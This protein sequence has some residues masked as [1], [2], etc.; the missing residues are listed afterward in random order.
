[1]YMAK[2]LFFSSKTGNDQG[3]IIP[4]DVIDF[5]RFNRNPI[6][7]REHEWKEDP[8]GLWTDIQ[9]SAAGWSGIPVFHALTPESER[10][11]KLYDGDWIRGASI[12]GLAIWKTNAADQYVLDKNGFRQCLKF[13][14]YEISIVTLPSNPDAVTDEPVALSARVYDQGELNSIEQSITTLSS[15]FYNNMEK[16]NDPV[17]NT[18]QTAA[19]SPE[20]AA[21]AAAEPAARPVEG[22]GRI[23]LS[24]NDLPGFLGKI[25]GSVKAAL[26]IDT[27]AAISAPAHK[28]VPVSTK[29]DK[30][31]AE[32][33][34]APTGLS[35]VAEKAK[36][37]AESKLEAAEKA[38]KK[39]EQAKEK[40]EAENASEE[41]KAEHQKSMEA[42]KQAV[43]EAE[44]AQADY[45]N[46]KK[47]EDKGEKNT[48]TAAPNITINVS[49]KPEKKTL[50][51]LKA[52]NVKLA[53]KPQARVMSIGNG[54]TFS[55]LAA[56]KGEGERILN[57]VMT[58]DAGEKNFA[59]YA[60]VLNSILADGKYAALHEK[61]RLHSNVTEGQ[62]EAYRQNT[63]TRGIGLTLKELAAQ[64][65]AGHVE[66]WDRSTN[67]MK[68][69]STL[70]STDNALASPALNTIEW[71]PLAIFKMFPT[72]SWKNEINIFPAQM[73]GANTGIIWANVAANPTIYKG[74]QP[75]NPAD[76][77]YNDVAVGLALTPYWMQPM[78]WTPLTM[79]QLRYDQ[80]GTGWAQ[81]FAV[82]NA[83]IDDNLIYSLAAQVPA[84]SV[85]LTSGISGVSTT[86][87]TF[88][89]AGANDPNAFYWNP[90]FTGKLNAPTLNDIITLE[91]LY[92]KQNF[93]LG[94]ERPYLVMDSTADA[95]IS[96]DPETKSLLTRWVN[97]DGADMP[98]FKHTILNERSRVAIYDPAT[99]Q[100]KDPGAVIPATSVSACLGFVP[101]KVGMG[102]GMLDVFMVQDP[103]NYGYKMSADIRVGATG[104]YDDK[105]GL[106]L[107][108]Y[109]AAV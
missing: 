99:K 6:V 40:A 60:A 93:E 59:D 9:R 67:S 58:R 10:T 92:K 108:T 109:S 39:A 17:E 11:K 22:E 1:M 56:D 18:T 80:Q 84:G 8:L 89:I 52:D 97:A 106:S 103:S 25:I 20:P 57:R 104:L 101:S 100:V 16:G 21:S 50:E 83:T 34:P 36:S 98:K 94:A 26:G 48:N 51:E 63:G 91:Q 61:M 90:A 72:T 31:V 37:K 33:Q 95:L 82:L 55:Q 3:G 53:A 87:I 70:S 77:S 76:Y 54:Q 2:R 45:E 75:A 41:D 105:S 69:I 29:T 24:A 47:G 71:L 85:V 102:L 23:T 43:N 68:E 49:M 4:D 7:L 28:D 107:L 15:K 65:N 81:A 13:I 12:G 62:L 42:A 44:E 86:P 64:L 96:K 38:V 27:N 79:H 78:R 66:I 19:G 14:L 35:A 74:N 88:N 5:S 46:A 30:D 32:P 73:T